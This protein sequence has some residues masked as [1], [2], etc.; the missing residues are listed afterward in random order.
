MFSGYHIGKYTDRSSGSP[1]SE[2]G[3]LF[4][5]H[6]HETLTLLAYLALTLSSILSAL[7]FWKSSGEICTKSDIV[8]CQ[9]VK[10]SKQETERLV[11]G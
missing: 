7:G 3:H 9:R 2:L 4:F 11:Q 8:V 5:F 6:G 1:G 10:L